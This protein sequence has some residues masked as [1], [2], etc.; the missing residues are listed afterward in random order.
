M[1]ST[2]FVYDVYD[3]FACD[4]LQRE[5]THRSILNKTLQHCERQRKVHTRLCGSSD[6]VE[7]DSSVFSSRSMCAFCLISLI[8]L[9][10]LWIMS[11]FFFSKHKGFRQ[12][13]MRHIIT[14]ILKDI[15]SSPSTYS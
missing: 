13:P 2:L 14:I 11:P 4:N 15:F 1:I 9:P 7:T 8:H 10:Q 12:D 6:V 3:V 5:S